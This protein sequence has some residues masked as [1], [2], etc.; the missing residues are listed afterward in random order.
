[1]NAISYINIAI[2]SSYDNCYIYAILC[3][4]TPRGA[5]WPPPPS[6]WARLGE[7]GSSRFPECNARAK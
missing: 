4:T 5:T 1:M 6:G 7:G 2:I 3:N